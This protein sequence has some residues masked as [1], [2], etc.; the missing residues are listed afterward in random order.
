MLRNSNGISIFLI[1][2]VVGIIA[3]AFILILPQVMD[4]QRKENTELC[5]KNMREL[6]NAIRRY[7]NERGESF[8]G[9]AADLNRT[10]YL[11][12]AVYVCPEGTPESRYFMEGD[13]QTGKITITCP[14]ADEY[15]DHKLPTF[16]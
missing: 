12:R 5:L 3:L 14:H 11:K 4:I 6:E 7:M 15:P 9:D 13:F 1:I 10:G 2:S 8:V 16:E